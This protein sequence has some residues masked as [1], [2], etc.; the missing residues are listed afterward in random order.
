MRGS[1]VCVIT[2]VSAIDSSWRMVFWRSGGNESAMRETVDATS[3]VCTLDSTRWPGLRRGERDPHRLRVAHLADDDHVRRLAQRR[4]Q[5]GREIGRVDADLDLLD[6]AAAG[7]RAR[8]SI[9]SSIV[10]MWRASRRLISSTTAASVVDLPEPVAPPMSTRP[11]VQ[12]RQ[13]ST[14]GGRSSEARRGTSVGRAR[15]AAAA[16]P[17][18]RCRLM[19]KRP[20]SDEPVRRVGDA[21]VAVLA[22][23]RAPA[24]REHRVFDRRRRRAARRRAGRRARRRG[25]RRAR[26]RRAADRWRAGD[27]LA[28][29]GS[30]RARSPP[31]DAPSTPRAMAGGAARP[32]VDGSSCSSRSE[33]FEILRFVHGSPVVRDGAERVSAGSRFALSQARPR[34][35]HVGASGSPAPR[36]MRFASTFAAGPQTRVARVAGANRDALW[37]LS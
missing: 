24:A 21:A 30:S 7:A 23:R 37:H 1:S 36:T 16:R 2:A 29:P 8:Y 28:Q 27:Q 11:R 13:G 12:L 9:G 18:S 3:V 20:T 33:G 10:M 19:R 25:S 32:G 31:P 22:R 14:P 15:M 17:R 35:R 34:Q 5:R 4:A 6:Q 26:R